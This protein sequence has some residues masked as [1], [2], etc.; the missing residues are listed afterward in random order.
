MLTWPNFGLSFQ[1]RFEALQYLDDCIM[2]DAL[3]STKDAWIVVWLCEPRFGSLSTLY[4][5]TLLGSLSTS[6]GTLMTDEPYAG[7]AGL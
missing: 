6:A 2:K 4:V 7:K 5:G 1:N 3:V